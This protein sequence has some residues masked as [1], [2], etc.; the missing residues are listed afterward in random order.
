[1]PQPEEIE[2]L[3]DGQLVAR[4][5]AGDDT[6]WRELVRRFGRYV[7]AITTRAYRLSESDAE[8]VFQEVFARTY[9]HLDRL[10]DDEAIKPWIAQLTRRLAVDRLRG[11]AREAP[12]AEEDAPEAG[13]PDPVLDRLDEALSVHA[14]MASLTPECREVLERFF[15]RDESYRNIADALGLSMGTVASRLSR[16]LS[17]LRTAFEGN[18]EGEGRNRVAATS[19]GT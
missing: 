11:G 15:V 14:A 19:G 12:A 17:R 10:R 18:S 2:Q 16:C 13:A 7:Y 4:C 1:M 6:A 9:Q 3:S 8:D 5:R